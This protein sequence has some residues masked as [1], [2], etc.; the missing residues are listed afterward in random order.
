MN[1]DDGLDP[2]TPA[3]RA[4]ARAVFLVA[5]GLLGGGAYLAIRWLLGVRW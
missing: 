1:D 3:Q 5:S 2:M 4:V